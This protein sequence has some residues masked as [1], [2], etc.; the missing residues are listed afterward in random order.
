MVALVVLAVGFWVSILA[1]LLVATGTSVRDLVSG[2][3]E[4]LPDH[5]GTWVEQEERTDDLVVEERCLLAPGDS[6]LVYQRR[7]LDSAVRS[8]VRVDADVLVPRKRLRIKGA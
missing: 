2:K 5:L 7:Y 1:V 4:P 6:Q 3:L 8:I